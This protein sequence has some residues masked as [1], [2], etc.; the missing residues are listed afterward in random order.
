MTC[1]YS[2]WPVVTHSAATVG[3]AKVS[4]TVVTWYGRNRKRPRAV[5]RAGASV[6]V[7]SDIFARFL[8]L[9]RA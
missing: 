9:L 5:L 7:E 2:S 3:G 6:F 1:S 8:F 4:G